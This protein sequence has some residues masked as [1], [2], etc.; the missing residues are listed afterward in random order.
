MGKTYGVSRSD[1]NQGKSLKV[2]AEE[3]GG[4]DFISFNLYLTSEKN[5]LKACEMPDQKVVD[6][7]LH[8]QQ[9]MK[10]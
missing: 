5:L 10:G 7:I 3:L 8:S 4:K 1:F 6:F 2:Y 9:K